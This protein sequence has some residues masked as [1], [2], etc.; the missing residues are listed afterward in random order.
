[1]SYLPY[2]IV[3]VLASFISI[4]LGIYG[5]LHRDRPGMAAFSIFMFLSAV[6]PMA[7]AFDIATAD[8][9]LKIFLMK[10][11]LDAPVF[12][13]LAYFVMVIQL[14]GKSNWITK[15][16]LVFLSIIPIIGIFFN[17]TSPNLLFRYGYHIITGGPFPVLAWTN[18]PFFIIW[19]LYIYALFLVPLFL[20]INSYR[21]IS[22]LTSRQVIILI[23][24]TSIPVVINALFQIG[25]TPISGFNL[26]PI[27]Q[28]FEGLIIVW[29]VFYVKAFDTVPI[30]RDKLITDMKESVM[31]VDPQNRILD[32]NPS[33]FNMI[34][35]TADKAIGQLADEVFAF[36]PDLL[37]LFKDVKD[38]QIEIKL[39]KNPI[40]YFDVNISSLRDKNGQYL[41][42]M[43]ILRDISK[44]K[45]IDNELKESEIKYRSLYS[46]MSEGV[47]LHNIIYNQYKKPVNY[48]ISDINQSYENIIGLKRDEIVGK[49]ASEVYST[50]KPPYMEIYA[51]VAETGESIQFQ[52]HLLKKGNF[53]LFLKTLQN[54]K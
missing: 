5:F 47:A 53:T 30:A 23:I 46:S 42:R 21:S 15:Q 12:A 6:W 54:L 14:I 4:G 48:I 44:R 39:D 28:V 17:W 8:L 50:N 19:I 10:I 32:M 25:I 41:G 24:A 40:R 35:S 33:A 7:Q 38:E 11:R 18:G 43:F 51:K 2:S 52:L 45:Y 22:P 26:E 37:V 34:G 49:K 3:L 13:I 9:T 20:L 29:G 1:M 27:A 36:W 31:V 16:R